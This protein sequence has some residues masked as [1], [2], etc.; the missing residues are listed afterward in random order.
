MCQN[1]ASLTFVGPDGRPDG[2][3]DGWTDGRI[4]KPVRGPRE[5]L[6]DLISPSWDIFCPYGTPRGTFFWGLMRDTR[7]T[8]MGPLLKSLWGLGVPPGDLSSPR[9]T[10][11]ILRGPGPI[12]ESLEQKSSGRCPIFESFDL[13]S[14]ILASLRVQKRKFSNS[15][16]T[17]QVPLGP[18]SPPWDPLSPC[19]TRHTPWDQVSPC[20]T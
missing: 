20:G 18:D 9:E 13:K 16:I 15:W 17:V 19:G 11:K 12:F 4:R 6:R 1:A 7:D 3:T 14:N 10:F 2:R 8:K 5:S